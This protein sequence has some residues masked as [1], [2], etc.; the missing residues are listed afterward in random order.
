MD[1]EPL[2]PSNLPPACSP[3]P[4]Q[5]AG[6]AVLIFVR[7]STVIFLMA[8]FW[9]YEAATLQRILSKLL[10]AIPKLFRIFFRRAKPT[11]NRAAIPPENFQPDTA[12]LDKCQ[13][14]FHDAWTPPAPRA[15]FER[16]RLMRI[17]TRDNF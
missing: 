17:H 5:I 14:N 16:H 6:R 15:C 2:D 9:F 8:V 11:P 10:C 13:N 4:T 7:S 3:L 12:P 1:S